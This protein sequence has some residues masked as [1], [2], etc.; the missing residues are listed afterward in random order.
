MIGRTY[1]ERGEPV[2]V[3]IRWG[4]GGGPRN[5][6]IRRSDGSLVVRPFRDLR[7]PRPTGGQR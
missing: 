6:L 7:R 1:L 3:L 5:V 4:P 2:V